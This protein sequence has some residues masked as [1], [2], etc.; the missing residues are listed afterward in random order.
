MGK[1]DLWIAA[2]ASVYDLEFLTMDKDFI[3][4]EGRYLRLKMVDLAEY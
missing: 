3:H 2:T 1:N 4:L